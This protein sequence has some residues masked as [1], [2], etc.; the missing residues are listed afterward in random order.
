MVVESYQYYNYKITVGKEKCFLTGF[1]WSIS[2]NDY[3]L[4]IVCSNLNFPLNNVNKFQPPCS[5]LAG[6][7]NAKH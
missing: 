7:F 4:E 1:Y 3:E 5:I 6:D 2:Q